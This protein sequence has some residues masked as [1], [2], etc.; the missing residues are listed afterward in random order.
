MKKLNLPKPKTNIQEVLLHL[1]LYKSVS[2]MDYSYMSGFRT[3]V[4]QLI[5][6]HG[7]FLERVFETKYNVH[8]NAYSYAIHTLPENQ[9]EKAIQIYINLNNQKS[10]QKTLKTKNGK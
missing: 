3:R 6:N 1:I 5:L 7:L 9:K 4:S 10:C 8:G 2:I